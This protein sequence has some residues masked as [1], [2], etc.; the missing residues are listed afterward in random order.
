M[1]ILTEQPLQEWTAHLLEPLPMLNAGERIADR[2]VTAIALG[3]FTVGQKLPSEREIAAAMQ[4]SRGVVREALQ[5][6]AASGY[7]EVRRG[8]HG[9]PVVIKNWAS[10]APAMIQRTLVPEWHRL[11]ELLDARAL[12]ESQ[13]ARTAAL[14]RTLTDIE[15]I[16]RAV[17]SY[18]K[19]DND[20]ESSGR[21]DYVF[22]LSIA[23]AAHNP[24]LEALSIR[25]RQE[26]NLGFGVEPFSPEIRARALIQHPALAEAVIDGVADAAADRAATHF[27]LTEEL[28]RK[29]K[30]QVEERQQSSQPD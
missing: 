22:H 23:R 27:S 25:L 20:R 17:R 24:I 21:A 14:R 28:L 1:N 13:I 4:V 10:D 5:R 9:G 16:R 19:A 29:L 18:I 26:V 7:I 8:R 6:L 2:L 12:I 30:A 3:Q 11:E 15:E